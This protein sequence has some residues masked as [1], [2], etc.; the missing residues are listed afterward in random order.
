MSSDKRESLLHFLLQNHKNLRLKH[1]AITMAIEKFK[2]SR[3]SVKRLW[4]RAKVS[5]K[6]GETI[7]ALSKRKG[8]CGRKR[9]DR[10]EKLATIR[11]IDVNRRTTLRALS[12]SID[13]PLTS[14]W[15]LCKNGE[16]KRHSNSLKP[17]LTLG[18][19]LKRLEYCL[20]FVEDNGQF[21]DM[22]N[23]IH[24][25]EKWFYITKIKQNFYLLPEES[26][27]SRQVKSKSN[28]IKVMF[29]AAIGRPR[30]D[31]QKK[32]Y[33]DGKLGIW[34]FVVKEPAQRNS[35]N[36]PKGTLV[37]KPIELTK[38][39]Y[40]E[41]LINNLLPAV[42]QKWPVG[43]RNIIIQHDNAKPHLINFEDQRFH[44]ECHNNGWNISFR[45]QPPNSPDLNVLDLCFF[46][47]IQSIQYQQSPRN[48]D[49]LIEIVQ[50]A[51]QDVTR[52]AADNVFLSLQMAMENIMN[53]G[54]NNNYKLAH[55]SK[56]KL[57]REG[58]LPIS[59]RCKTEVI[60]AAK[61]I[62]ARKNIV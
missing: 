21:K 43:M 2:I 35:K 33:F 34:P 56:E 8:N 37:T 55:M 3:S 57:R 23:Y 17:L 51:F 26:E 10:K 48:I 1:D 60:Q 61:D 40:A 44:N 45:Y 19:Q 25:D 4:A 28:M 59:I 41:M 9:K 47:S 27:P 16:I 24:I 12:H 14:L 58:Q 38:S 15:R 46:S 11:N 49:E 50:K 29:L 53:C 42:K 20:S 18:N 6:N 13:I 22:F 62:L 7:S 32:Q 39:V 52:T 5:I 31:F 54:G 30:Y 36:R